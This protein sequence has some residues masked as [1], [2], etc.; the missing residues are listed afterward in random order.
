MGEFKFS[1]HIKTS[2]K[3]RGGFRTYQL[4]KDIDEDFDQYLSSLGVYITKY[5]N[6]GENENKETHPFSSYS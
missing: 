6:T 4:T 3:A 1:Q 5:H 2:S